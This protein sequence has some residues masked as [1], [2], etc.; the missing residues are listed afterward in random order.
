M[1]SDTNVESITL[2]QCSVCGRHFR[3]D[4]INRHQSVCLKNTTKK[5]KVFDSTKQRTQGIPIANQK[6]SINDKSAEKARKLAQVEARKH[7]WR[8][9]HEEFIQSIRAA[10]EYTIAK[11]TGRPLPPPP[12]PTIDPDLIQSNNATTTSSV[13]TGI[14]RGR[15]PARTSLAAKGDVP[16][17]TTTNPSGSRRIP[18]PHTTTESD[19]RPSANSN[20]SSVRNVKRTTPQMMK[21]A[22]TITTP[23]ARNSRDLHK[24]ND[25]MIKP[26]S[27]SSKEETVPNSNRGVPTS[28]TRLQAN[29]TANHS[30]NNLKPTT[31]AMTND[32]SNKFCSECG[33]TFPSTAARFCPE[34][35]MRRMGF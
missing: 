9:K 28:Q 6:S 8:Q 25:E 3:E 7:N 5:R 13:N 29:K 35:G 11:Q 33:S 4:I 24:T 16:Q 2:I 10:K 1:D 26:P 21:P 15:V 23:G 18:V 19:N 34:C 32:K 12:P 27:N 22:Q 20:F 17:N 31:G 14:G 30:R